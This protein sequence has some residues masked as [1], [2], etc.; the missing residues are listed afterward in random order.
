MPAAAI[1]IALLVGALLMLVIGISPAAAYA[2]LWAGTFATKYQIGVTLVKATP[3]M[4]TAMGLGFAFRSGVFNIGAEGQIYIGA[5]CGTFIGIQELGLPIWA[6]LPLT[7]FAGF[8]G[9]GVW[10][11]IPGFLKARYRVNEVITTILMN[12]IAILAVS[13]FTH[14]PLRADRTS[15]ASMPH[16]LEVQISSRLPVIWE[17]TR[18]HAGIVLAVLAVAVMAFLTYRTVFGFKART[19]GL[20]P[21]AAR[22]AGMSVVPV[23]TL[24]MLISGGLAGMAGTVEILGVQRRLRDQFLSGTGYTAIAI[25]LFGRNDPLGIALAAILFGALEAGASNMEALAGVPSTLVEIIQAVII[26]LVAVSVSLPA[27]TLSAWV[28][29]L[30]PW[31]RDSQPLGGGIREP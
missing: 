20:S 6:H 13:Y 26:F 31:R 12:Y 9:G 24:A 18:L 27:G 1:V 11:A 17:G 30:T 28:R 22:Y 2:Q 5:L 15:A 3:L 29:R 8:L 4:L 16:T 10:G 19:V 23:I 7:L 14:G 25:A 21:K